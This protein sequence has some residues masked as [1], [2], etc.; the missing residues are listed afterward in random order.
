MSEQFEVRGPHEEALEHGGHHA[1]A[2][3]GDARDPFAGRVAV[4][5]AV[6]ATVG[7]VFAYQGGSTEGLALFY[8]NEA[9]I[10]KTEAANQWS[11][12]QAK[13]EKQNLAELGAAL[14]PPE[15][16]ANAKFAADIA[17][18][19]QQKTE[20]RAHAEALE[21]TVLEADTASERQLH[22]HHRWAQAT[23]LTQVAISLA[24]IT[25]LTRRRWL[26][27]GAA[28]TA[29]AGVLVGIAAACGV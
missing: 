4:M 17:K 6:L 21:K 10:R 23:T 15:S 1:H 18:Y 27:W 3:P 26:L 12:Y 22:M 20:I 9:A 24:A 13:G 28:A 25:L 11:Y 2:S 19:A 14:S 8:K 7:A 16:K 5:T 29:G